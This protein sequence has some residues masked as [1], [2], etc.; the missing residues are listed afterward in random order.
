V[1]PLDLTN[2]PRQSTLSGG[3]PARLTVFAKVYEIVFRKLGVY[4]VEVLNDYILREKMAH[5]KFS[6]ACGQNGTF[7]LSILECKN[8]PAQKL[9]EV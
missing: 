1:K 5:G 2:I 8:L 3:S 6:S 7:T 4:D 9:E